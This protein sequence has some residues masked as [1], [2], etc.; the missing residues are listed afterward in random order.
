MS[1]RKKKGNCSNKEGKLSSVFDWCRTPTICLS[2]VCCTVT[3]ASQLELPWF[4]YFAVPSLLDHMAV[5]I[6]C[7]PET[8][9]RLIKVQEENYE[10]DKFLHEC[11]ERYGYNP[12]DVAAV[13]EI[14]KAIEATSHFGICKAELSKHFCSYEQVEAERSRSLE[15]YIQVGLQPAAFHTLM[16]ACLVF[17]LNRASFQPV[18]SN[19]KLNSYLC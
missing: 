9:T 4:I 2:A 15:Q 18:G 13:L 10:V 19:Y 11:T 3:A 17:P 14:R 16:F 8:F 12:G 5:G 7:L 6:S 1:G